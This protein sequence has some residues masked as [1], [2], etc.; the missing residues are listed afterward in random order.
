MT[1]NELHHRIELL[2]DERDHWRNEAFVLA[3]A[4]MS[5]WVHVNESR[6]SE[7]DALL[8]RYVGGSTDGTD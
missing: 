8:Q 3:N 2:S 4:L 6:I 7:V 5:D 1:R